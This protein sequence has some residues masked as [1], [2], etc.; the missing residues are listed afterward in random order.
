VEARAVPP[1]LQRLVRGL[2]ALPAWQDL[3]DAP[4]QPGAWCCN[5]PLWCNPWLVAEPGGPLPWRGL[6]ARFGC[7]ARLGT[8]NTV[9]EAIA[10]HQAV[11]CGHAVYRAQLWPFWMGSHPVFADWDVADTLL[12]QL[13][14]AIPAGIR[15]AVQ[16]AQAQLSTQQLQQLPSAAQVLDQLVARL[17]W[18]LPGGKACQ[19]QAMPVRGFTLLQWPETRAPLRARLAAFAQAVTA[20][21]PPGVSPVTVE[22]VER[23]LGRAWRVPW[24]NQRKEVWW[25]LVLDGLPTAARM[26][27]RQDMPCACG[28][29]V[30]GWQHHFW[31]CPVAKA[32][33]NLLQGQLGQGAP[34]LQPQHLWLAWV[35]APGLHAGVWRVVA[36]AALNALSKAQALLSRWQLQGRQAG[37]VVPAHV[38][39]PL[40]RVQVASRV[41]TATVWDLLQDFVALRAFPPTWVVEVPS[42]H[43]FVASLVGGG[44][45][46]VL[47]VR[48]QP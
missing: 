23:C 10:A 29:A 4:L 21:H 9:A 28:E 20:T 13:V 12:T 3:G 27:H 26:G 48:R 19:L 5:M 6:E 18:R 7:V 25:R 34:A 22:Q 36:L 31:H 14:A 1:P 30:P 47:Y 8:I 43:P 37:R 16:Q 41:A 15:Q 32:V 38:L 2:Q 45:E 24:D 39:T 17:G 46:R 35:P 33:V 44:G 40:G 42:A 11:H